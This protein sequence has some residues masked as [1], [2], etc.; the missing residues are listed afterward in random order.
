MAKRRDKSRGT[1]ADLIML[2]ILGM[3]GSIIGSY[4]S[5]AF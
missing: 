1:A 5:Y 3:A 4:F 2:G